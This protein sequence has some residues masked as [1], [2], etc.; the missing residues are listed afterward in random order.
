M[1]HYLLLSFIKARWAYADVAKINDVLEK[2]LKTAKLYKNRRE[3]Y[4]L[5]KKDFV[6]LE[7]AARDFEPYKNLW[8]NVV[9]KAIIH[10]YASKLYVQ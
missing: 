5:K 7:K 6:T 8:N 2:L 4:G 9:G 3:K 10:C 1:I